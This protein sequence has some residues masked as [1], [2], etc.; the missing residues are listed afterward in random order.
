MGPLSFR[1]TVLKAAMEEHEAG[2]LSGGEL[3]ALRM[4]LVFRPHKVEEAQAAVIENTTAKGIA[5]ADKAGFD[6][7]FFLAL[8]KEL[9]PLIMQ[10]ISMFKKG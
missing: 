3:L 6:W 2:N 7:S 10:I 4:A 8:I 1:Q 5:G 9:L